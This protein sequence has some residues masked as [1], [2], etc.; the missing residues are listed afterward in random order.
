MRTL[1]S[2][3]ALAASAAASGEEAHMS[4]LKLAF[5]QS[6]AQRNIDLVL[7]VLK[8]ATLHVVVGSEPQPGREPEWFLTESPTEGRYCVTASESEGA[9]ADIRW[10]KVRL[11]GEQLLAAL[12]PGIEIVIVYVDGGDYLNREQLAWYRHSG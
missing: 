1:I 7:P 5:Q 11:S 9:M 2:A 6:R 8:A 4:P 3:L 12:P 10:P